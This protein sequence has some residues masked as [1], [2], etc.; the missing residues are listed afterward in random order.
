MA[1]AQQQWAA[2]LLKALHIHQ[3]P[4][5]VQALTGWEN[6]EGGHFHNDAH[7]NPLNTTQN[8]PGAGNT[9]SQGNIKQY[10]NWQQGIQAT[11]ETL[12]NGRYNGI[13]GALQSGDPT[14]VANAIGQTPWGTSGG[15]VQRT[16]A[17]TPRVAGVH[18]MLS[19]GASL[20][21]Q[22]TPRSAAS[23][24][25]ASSI[26]EATHSFDEGGYQ[27]ARGLA[28]LGQYLAK[29]NPN[30]PLLKFGLVTTQAPDITQFEHT[31]LETLTGPKLSQG[32]QS[33]GY[34]GVTGDLV[35]ALTA[36]ANT[37][38]SHH[39]PYQWGGGHGGKTAPAAA[40]PVDCSG[41]VS[42]VLGIDPR[43]ASQFKSFGKPG[44]GRVTIYAKDT[45][46]IMEINGH[47]FGTS[48]TNPGG[49]AGW[50]PRSAI[51]PQY[52]KGF[53]ARHIDS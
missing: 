4:G 52:L 51:S 37:V 43:V 41:A 8:E 15:L 3:T 20:P 13:L 9:G 21:S 40:V 7:F 33:R 34:S 48:A 2:A 53:T 19:G 18:A 26:T 30:N 27:H 45:H 39:L 49:G 11:V 47:F 22:Q 32:I 23:G 17:N 24:T 36:R 38:D 25:G 5:A 14:A 10:K 46:V 50:I 35:Q 1:T 42:E 28:I 31:N 44:V 16:I 29:R 12:R 6:A